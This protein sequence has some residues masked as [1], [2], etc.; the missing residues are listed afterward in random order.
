MERATWLVLAILAAVLLDALIVL[1]RMRAR[2]RQEPPLESGSPRTNPAADGLPRPSAR[3]AWAGVMLVL[4]GLL[5]AVAQALGFRLPEQSRWALTLPRLLGLVLFSVGA[6]RLSLASQGRGGWLGPPGAA[7]FTLADSPQLAALEARWARLRARLRLPSADRPSRPTKVASVRSPARKKPASRRGATARQG[8]PATVTLVVS[9]LSLYFG[10]ALRATLP[11]GE[12]TPASIA[13]ILGLLLFLLTVRTFSTGSF[14]RILQRPLEVIALW[15]GVSSAQVMLLGLAIMLSGAAWLAAGDFPLMLMP[16][17]AVALWV[18]SALLFLMGAWQTGSLQR[19]RNWPRGEALAVVGLFLAAFLARGIR[20]A[21]IPWLLTG[22]ESSGGLSALE[23]IRGERDNPFGVGWFEF[24]SLYFFVQS[25]SIR[26][27]G[28]TIE[29]LRLTSAL[30]GALTVVATYWFLRETFGRWVALAGATYLSAFHFHIHFSRIGLNN[31]WDALFVSLVSAAFWRGW[32]R[33]DRMSFALTG[34]VLGLAQYFYASGRILFLI[35]PAWL[36]V[37][38]LRDRKAVRAHLPGLAIILLG[39]MVVAFPQG[40]YYLKHKDAFAAPF[41][42]VSLFGPM[43]QDQLSASGQTI[44]KV[45]GEQFKISTLAFT[46]TNLTYWYQPGH[47]MLLP[48][49]AALFLMG[50]CLVLLNIG[51]FQELWL[52][53]WVAG[54]IVVG[55]LSDSPPAA[56]RYVFVAPAVVGII[57]LSLERSG[58]WLIRAWPRLRWVTLASLAGLLV[59]ACWEDLRFYFGDFSANKRFGDV[60]TEVATQV[61]RYLAK[62]EPGIQVY[63]LGGRMGYYSH[64]TIPYLAPRAVG[65]DVLDALTGPPDWD[66][67][68]PTIFILLPERAQELDSLEQSYPGGTYIRYPGKEGVLFL[69]YEVPGG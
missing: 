40:L 10:Q 57:G 59:L 26:L 17:L 61:G 47:P 58:S 18:G 65:N 7:R 69:A 2:S 51:R 67:P 22:D 34:L 1:V 38:F 36:V 24:P 53:L 46:G 37:V 60:N 48:I 29:A 4:G 55:A 23:F 25:V 64:A 33:G 30:A 42:R 68:G 43:L 50:A 21:D 49:P 31:A 54:A 16:A 8:Q 12:R 63:F 11:E 3:T 14:P 9:A 5:I 56:Q 62:K 41:N 32:N 28:Q 15:L 19:I 20:T 52:A 27:F 66:L 39:A 35:L 44:W 45:L 6:V 13:T